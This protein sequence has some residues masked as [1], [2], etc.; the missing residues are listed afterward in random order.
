[1]GG[2]EFPQEITD[3]ILKVVARRFPDITSKPEKPFWERDDFIYVTAEGLRRKREEHRVLV[4]EKI[5]ANATAIGNAAALGDL[6]E[7]SEWEAAMEEQ[8]N[9]TGRAEEM[10]REIRM[11]RLIENQE[12]PTEVTAP[13]MKVDFTFL[14]DGSTQSYRILGPWDAVEDDI[15]NYRAPLAKALLGHRAGDEIEIDSPAGSRT[16]RI[17]AVERIV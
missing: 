2:S 7:N 9:L 1:R 3:A 15:L 16:A 14:D 8:R 6:S 4:D 13:G 5:P 11:A 10:S 17:D 12:L